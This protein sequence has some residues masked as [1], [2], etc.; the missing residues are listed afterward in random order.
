[1][2]AR[3]MSVPLAVAT[4]AV[5]CVPMAAQ[6]VRGTAPVEGTRLGDM[7]RDTVLY[8]KEQ[9]DIVFSAQGGFF[10]TNMSQLVDDVGYA[11][12]NDIPV[13]ASQLANDAG[14]LTRHQSLE[15]YAK[16]N[17]IPVRVSQLDNDAGYVTAEQVADIV[18]EAVRAA[19]GPFVI[20]EDENGAVVLV[21]LADDA[22]GGESVTN[23]QSGSTGGSTQE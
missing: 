3:W 20:M 8:T 9:A 10:P 12:T 16:T 14:Y 5:A 15:G 1:M 11:K 21:R 18:A 23:G 17:D 13:R 6:R 7:G 19:T 2:T 4:I 22:S